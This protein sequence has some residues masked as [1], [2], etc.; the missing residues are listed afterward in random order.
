MP[1]LIGVELEGFDQIRTAVTTLG[2]PEDLRE[3]R[4]AGYRVADMVAKGGRA[5]ARGDLQRKAAE[6][7]KPLRSTQ[8][9]VI[10]Y[11][12]GFPAAMGAMFGADRG[13]QRQGRPGGKPMPIE[14]WNQF[15]PWRRQEGYFLWPYMR[16]HGDEIHETFADE[17]EPLL[18]R[19]FPE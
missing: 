6:T 15:E 5:E 11:G 13:Q 12:R 17:I 1:K 10:Q 8:G 2:T 14:G 9:A 3:W 4:A 16:T 19:M 7:L 18:R